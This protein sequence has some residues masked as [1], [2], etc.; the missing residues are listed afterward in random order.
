MHTDEYEISLSRE[1]TVCRKNVQRLQKRLSA[2]EQRF[3]MTAEELAARCNNEE[4]GLSK[5][6]KAWMSDCRALA[7]WQT[8]LEQYEEQFLLM[9]I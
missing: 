4:A 6:F 2:L 7:G 9:K 1:L 8:R 3:G 5:E